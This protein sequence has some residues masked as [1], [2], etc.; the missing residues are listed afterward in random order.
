MESVMKHGVAAG[1]FFLLMSRGIVAQ[2]TAAG[3]KHV[4]SYIDPSQINY[5]ALLAPPPKP[6]TPASNADFAAVHLA[7]KQR[8]PAEVS[9]AQKDDAEEDIF[10]YANVLGPEFRAADLPLTAAFSA[11]LRNESGVVNPALKKY[12]ARPRPFVADKTV[13]PVCAKTA[14][15]SYPSGHTMVGYLTGLALAQMVPEKADAILERAQ[16]YA[17]NRVVCGVHYPTDTEASREIAF[18]MYGAMAASAKFQKDF[19]AA[20]AETRSHL[21]LPRE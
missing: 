17:Y 15:G 18:A 9:A 16:Q 11:H 21:H 7:E 2:Q 3:P 13:H 6:G 19:A 5:S 10:I 8:T 12:F 14:E 4:P 20:R 1:C